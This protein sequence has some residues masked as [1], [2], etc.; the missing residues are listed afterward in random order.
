MP[1]FEYKAKKKSAETVMGEV[2]AS[3]YNG[4]V[5]KITEMGLMPVSIQEKN[6]PAQSPPKALSGRVASKELY[7]FT[8]QLVSLLKSG[9]PL[10]R[11][12]DII[13][14]Q[15]Q[16]PYFREVLQDI[17]AHIRN[18]ETFSNSLA[19]YPKI[20]SSLY[21]T[22]ARAGEEGGNLKDLLSNIA[23]FQRGQEEMNSKVRSALAYPL[24]MAI[25]GVG[26]VIFILTFVMPRITGLFTSAGESLPLATLILIKVSG[27]FQKIWFW[28]LLSAL[29]L[30]ILL[31]SRREK[32]AGSVWSHR[33]KL[34]LPLLG[35]LILKVELARFCRTLELLLKSGTSILRA[36]S[37]TTPTLNNELIRREFVKCQE[38]LTAGSTFGTSLKDSK[39]IPPIMGNLIAVGEESG[40]LAESLGDLADTYEQESSE[41]IKTLTNLFEPLMILF[42]GLVIGFIVF[43]MML[44]IFQ[45][46]V[47]AR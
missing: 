47:F 13:A 22:M 43:A 14:A 45:I 25:V 37:I 2:N 46:D 9:V 35:E 26:T 1:I 31:Q 10:L 18:G 41:T 44:P 33:L 28:I 30:F 40:S 27:I 42:V 19:L 24:L 6:P 23:M 11:S 20:Y 8:R 29:A 5:D 16:N 7:V 32:Q 38:D 36:M 4:A 39:L 34:R 12:L 15:I 21:V 17:A 3:S